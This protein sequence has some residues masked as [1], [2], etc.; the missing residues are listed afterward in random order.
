MD[1][2]NILIFLAC[3]IFL[4]L[5]GKF[6]A[7]PL[8]M[9]VKVIG[10]SIVGGCIIFVVNIIG[11]M[12]GFHIG[13]NIVTTVV[14]GILGIPRCSTSYYTKNI[15]IKLK[16]IVIC[17][18]I[19]CIKNKEDLL[20]NSE[21]ILQTSQIYKCMKDESKEALLERVKKEVQKIHT[22]LAM[23]RMY[24]KSETEII[25]LECGYQIAV[26]IHVP[27]FV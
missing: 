7:V 16:K 1:T 11:G 14:A 3:I 5:I 24:D 15:S 23:Q 19:V 10:N 13:L 27:K 9:L 4:F 21:N 25:E 26:I 17:V 12:F 22:E 2:S 20:M 18:I 8:K 6:F